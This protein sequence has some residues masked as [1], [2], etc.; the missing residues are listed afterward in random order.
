MWLQIPKSKT[1]NTG[2]EKALGT[3]RARAWVY[4]WRHHGRC[5]PL[6]SPPGPCPSPCLRDVRR[7]RTAA[8]PRA[9]PGGTETSRG[10][11]AGLLFDAL[12]RA[13]APQRAAPGRVSPSAGIYIRNPRPRGGRVGGHLERDW[14][15][16][17]CPRSGGDTDSRCSHVLAE[18]PA[19]AAR[20]TQAHHAPACAHP[21]AAF[22]RG[23][24]AGR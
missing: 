19:W 9:P 23:A 8:A 14:Q 7:Q 18:G 4:E 20:P 11:A 12:P 5:A 3:H 15:E 24:G 10:T 1:R 21:L 6:R 22:T 13:F 2:L 16:K 17:P